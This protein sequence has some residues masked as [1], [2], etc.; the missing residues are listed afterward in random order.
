[1]VGHMNSR[2]WLL[3]AFAFVVAGCSSSVTPPMTG[4]SLRAPALPS[5]AV[6]PA[7]KRLPPMR[8]RIVDLGANVNPTRINNN[9]AVVG[10]QDLNYGNA[11]PVLYQRGTLTVL[12][13]YPG[14]VYAYAND[15]ND[16]GEIIGTS[17]G[18]SAD[19]A[20][21]FH[22]GGAP[23]LLYQGTQQFPGARALG[24]N[25]R[26]E[27]VGALEG[28]VPCSPGG[29][30]NGN[31]SG[32]SL[33]DVEVAVAINDNGSI[34]GYAPFVNAGGC[35][36]YS[37]AYEVNPTRQLPVPH[38]EAGVQGVVPTDINNGGTIVGSYDYCNVTGGPYYGCVVG[39]YFNCSFTDASSCGYA[40]YVYRDGAV[41]SIYSPRKTAACIM[42]DGVNG[43]GEMVGNL[44]YPFS[45]PRA[46]RVIGTRVTDLNTLLPAN[47]SWT[48]Q[49]ANDVNDRGVIVGVGK[50]N[51]SFHGYMLVPKV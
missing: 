21:I 9:N 20:V 18:G 45:A 24:I 41:T 7:V 15:I 11:L 2:R 19:H 16:T 29:E 33:P 3:V 13:V 30:F 40:G 26:G 6:G 14:D 37:T 34:A 22:P 38:D 23:T 8:Y 44:C 28:T 51:G 10:Y 12:G 5:K 50:L 27:A 31:G 25:A 17:I 1:M 39:G 47:C 42:L 46:V 32:V 43:D 48:L 35:N 4:A 36:G 49:Y